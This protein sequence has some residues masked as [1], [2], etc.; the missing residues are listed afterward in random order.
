VSYR[1][2]L[3][4]CAVAVAASAAVAADT[5]LK[6]KKL[7]NVE[8]RWNP[9]PYRDELMA[10]LQPGLTWRL[11]K[12]SATRLDLKKMALVAPG[13][14]VLLP[15]EQTLNLRFWAWD[16]WEL[17]VFEEDDWKWSEESTELGLFEA[18]VG[19]TKYEKEH[20]KALI[21]DLH[22]TTRGKPTRIERPAVTGADADLAELFSVP[23]DVEY[24]AALRKRWE[25]L[26][27]V[28]LIVRFGPH[29]AIVGFE[30]VP[31]RE[32]KGA[33]ERKDGK[34][35]RVTIVGLDLPEPAVRAQYLEEHEGELPIAVMTEAGEGGEHVVLHV[36]GSE[37]PVLWPR[38]RSGTDVGEPLDGTRTEAKLKKAP[39]SVF[40]ELNGSELS[41]TVAPWVYTFDLAQR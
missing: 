1:S 10:Q 33:F 32:L 16:N 28:E 36:S 9:V 38:T 4:V 40:C 19:P 35:R 22:E 29:K 30:P 3:C 37:L 23:D 41:V 7:G 14:G 26:P 5:E 15:G 6:I 39:N 18:T 17:V 27:W 8:I 11:G 24:E 31:L 21:L 13:S 34:K 25:A 2:F 12:E 20:T